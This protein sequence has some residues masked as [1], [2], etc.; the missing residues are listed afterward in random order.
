M[1]YVISLFIAC[2]VSAAPIQI[3]FEGEPQRAEVVKGIFVNDYQIPED[4]LA[5]KGV[6]NCD[7]NLKKGK[8]DLC[9]KNNGDLLLV[10]VDREFVNES[11]KI[12]RA[13]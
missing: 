5:L 4:L 11:L 8:L 10:S 12:F 7:W 13:P 9:L 2:N 1:K 3:F 6:A